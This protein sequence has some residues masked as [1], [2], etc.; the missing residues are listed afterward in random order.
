M[1][2][3]N[4]KCLQGNRCCNDITMCHTA[5][6]FFSLILTFGH[7]GKKLISNVFSWPP[8]PFMLVPNLKWCFYNLGC[9]YS[10]Y[11]HNV[12]YYCPYFLF[13]QYRASYKCSWKGQTKLKLYIPKQVW[14][15]KLPAFQSTQICSTKFSDGLQ[16]GND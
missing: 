13:N 11:M 3:Q 14:F 7:N 9:I 16:M 6:F 4:L 12:A 15:A 8:S 1:K 5:F 2:S 10:N